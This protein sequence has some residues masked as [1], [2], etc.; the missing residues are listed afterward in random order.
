MASEEVPP[1]LPSG[2][3]AGGGQGRTGNA[4][5]VGAAFRVDSKSLKDL[6]DTW[7]QLVT[8]IRDVNRELRNLGQAKTHIDDLTRSAN[9]LRQAVSGTQARFAG[10][11]GGV[12][13]LGHQQPGAGSKMPNTP[14]PDFGGVLQVRGGAGGAGGAGGI[15]GAGGMG[16]AGG[17]GGA[18]GGRGRLQVTPGAVAGGGTRAALLRLRRGL[19]SK[20]PDNMAAP[21]VALFQPR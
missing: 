21:Q 14:S 12:T 7:R 4:G 16:G 10:G 13:D 5:T 20:P 17:A 19:S 9:Q 11:A 18:G 8:D 15:G 6:H 3:S 2:G 1:G